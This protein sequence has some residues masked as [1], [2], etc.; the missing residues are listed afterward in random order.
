MNNLFTRPTTDENRNDERTF[1]ALVAYQDSETRD[2][3]LQICDRLVQKFWK[4]IEFDFSWWRFDFLRDAAIAKAAAMAARCADLIVISAHAGRELPPAV[5][6]W[7]ENW[8]PGRESE[9][10][11]LVAMIGTRQDQIRG[12][13]P[14]HVY[15]REAAQRVRM[16]FLPQVLDAPLVGLDGSIETITTRAEKVTAVL[17]HILHRPDVYSRWGIN[18]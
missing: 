9:T 8:L 2:G 17:D 1:A 7:V 4:D 16:D 6:K 10:G 18:E 15:L 3:A 13:S 11:L 12:L 14:I 5:Q